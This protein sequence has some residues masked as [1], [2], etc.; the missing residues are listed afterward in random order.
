MKASCRCSFLVRARIYNITDNTR[1]C[2]VPSDIWYIYHR[3][4]K[5]L[6]SRVSVFPAVIITASH[7]MPMESDCLIQ[8]LLV[9]S[10]KWFLGSSLEIYKKFELRESAWAAGKKQISRDAGSMLPRYISKH[11]LKGNEFSEKL[12][13]KI[14]ILYSWKHVVCLHGPPLPSHPCLHAV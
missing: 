10:H 7:F 5:V 12:T 1:P 13:S 11:L 2:D 6:C 8:H 3:S 4:V 9:S 14:S